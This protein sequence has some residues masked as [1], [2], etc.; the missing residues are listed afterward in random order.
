MSAPR[1]PESWVIYIVA[2]I[3]DSYRPLAVATLLRTDRDR[4]RHTKVIA[5]CHHLV[6]ILSDPSNKLAIASEMSL[7]AE[8]YH[9]PHDLRVPIQELPR[10][11]AQEILQNLG[12]PSMDYHRIPEFPFLSTSLL[13]AGAFAAVDTPIRVPLRTVFRDDDPYL[14]MI[15]FDISNLEDLKYGIVA[16]RS[17]IMVF[18][19]TMAAW[20][21]WTDT[22][23]MLGGRNELKVESER[24]RHALSA[25]MYAAKFGEVVV[26]SPSALESLSVV[27][28]A[29]FQR[30][31]KD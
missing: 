6:S 23:I 18:L 28:P 8:F 19:E 26:D 14:G 7:A 5:F 29:V 11:D 25:K 24:P 20:H 10:M 30:K 16:F 17:Q 15:V 31:L 12:G 3:I 27:E 21:Q 22:G 9:A 1:G 2:D 4:V 13:L